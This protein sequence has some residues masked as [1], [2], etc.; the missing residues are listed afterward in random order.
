[1]PWGASPEAGAVFSTVG[2]KTSARNALSGA[3]VGAAG[4]DRPA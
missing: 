2:W 3:G 1:M 4:R